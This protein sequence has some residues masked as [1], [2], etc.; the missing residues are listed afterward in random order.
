MVLC[1][2]FLSLLLAASGDIRIT[3]IMYNPDGPTLGDDDY[4]E[5]VELCN[6]GTTSIDLGGMMLSDGSNQLFLNAQ[7]LNAGE[8]IV[9]PASADSFTSVYG[10]GIL[11][12]TWSGEWTK[13]SNSG[14]QLLIYSEQG[15]VL[16][17]LIYSDSWGVSEE[18]TRSIAD[19]R[20]SS[21]EKI[22][23]TAPNNETNWSPSCDYA[24]PYADP[25]DGSSVCWG[26]PGER[27]SV[28]PIS[29]Q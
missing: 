10:N 1:S 23:I 16:D 21:L 22:D 26:T 14:D 29:D 25:D 20:G 5:W 9:I 15:D 7:V 13:L 8:R 18:A 12:G 27:N 19:G 4:F 17:E 11:I 6:T 28:E 24:C 2:L 3:E